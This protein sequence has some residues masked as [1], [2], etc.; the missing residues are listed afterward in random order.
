MGRDSVTYLPA[1]FTHVRFLARV[2]PH[3]D[4][5]GGSLDERLAAS[6]FG[7][8]VRSVVVVYSLVAGEVAASGEAFPTG[9]AR[10]GLGVGACG[11]GGHTRLVGGG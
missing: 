9:P 11:R 5:E 1:S 10:E 6:F 4:G 8:D 7:A 3:V 2:H